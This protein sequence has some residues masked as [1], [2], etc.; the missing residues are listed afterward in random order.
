MSCWVKN[1]EILNGVSLL[2][3]A[4]HVL[5]QTDDSMRGWVQYYKE[6]ALTGFRFARRK[7]SIKK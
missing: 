1:L 5:V 3:Q 2:N 7:N 4:P 6:I